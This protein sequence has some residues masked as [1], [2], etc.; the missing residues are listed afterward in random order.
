MPSWAACRGVLGALAEVAQRGAVNDR[1]NQAAMV[2]DGEDFMGLPSR[3]ARD[4][5]RNGRTGISESVPLM[6]STKSGCGMDCGQARLDSKLPGGLS[7]GSGWRCAGRRHECPRGKHECSPSRQRAKIQMKRA[8][9][10]RQASP[11]VGRPRACPTILPTCQPVFQGCLRHTGEY[12]FSVSM[13][14]V[15]LQALRSKS[16]A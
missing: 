10:A 12:H 4:R 16:S 14:M 2:T 7:A 3:G 15:T 11:A 9:D 8:G 13:L 6:I 5:L 1:H